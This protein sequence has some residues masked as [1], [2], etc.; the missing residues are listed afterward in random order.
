[1]LLD[2][3]LPDFGAADF[4]LALLSANIAAGAAILLVLVARGPVRRAAGARLAYWLWLTP[5]VA[6]FAGLIPAA[7]AQVIRIALPAMPASEA[8]PAVT[9]EPIA[10]TVAAITPAIDPAAILLILWVAGTAGCL[11]LVLARQARTMRSFTTRGMAGPAVVGVIRPRVIEPA[12]FEQRFSARERELILAHERTHIGAGDTRV[13]A[14][15]ALLT[16]FNWFNPLVHIA[17]RLARTDQELACDAAVVERFPGERRIYAEALLKTQLSPASLPLGCTWPTRSSNLLK[18]RVMMLARKSPG[19]A[20]RTAGIS[21]VAL[22]A[23]GA[24]LAAWAAQPNPPVYVFEQP[25][26]ADTPA[27]QKAP[28]SSE[29]PKDWLT[30]MKLMAQLMMAYRDRVIPLDQIIEASVTAELSNGEVL[31][32]YRMYSSLPNDIRSSEFANGDKG[33]NSDGDDRFVGGVLGSAGADGGLT[34]DFGLVVDGDPITVE[35]LKA[36]SGAS[37]TVE[38]NGVKL[39]IRPVLRAMTAAELKRRIPARK[40]PIKAKLQQDKPAKPDAGSPALD[41]GKRKVDEPQLKFGPG[42]P[43]KPGDTFEMIGPDGKKHQMKVDDLQL[44][45]DELKGPK[46][47]EAFN[48]FGPD[49]KKQRIDGLHLDFGTAKGLK[50]SDPGYKELMETLLKRRADGSDLV[51]LPPQQNPPP[52]KSE[53]ELKS[54]Y[55]QAS[56]EPNAPLTCDNWPSIWGGDPRA[57]YRTLKKTTPV[58]VTFDK[59]G[60]PSIDISAAAAAFPRDLY[61]AGL[62]EGEP[63]RSRMAKDFASYRVKSK[64]VMDTFTFGGLDTDRPSIMWHRVRIAKD[65]PVDTLMEG[66]CRK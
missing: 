30:H 5:I 64:T 45:L 47:G 34:L 60:L 39:T 4:L 13:N 26:P 2:I 31:G 19:R 8:A 66:H 44:Q 25:T 42:K 29:M 16:C 41:G 9:A 6:G 49:G 12:D 33:F 27:P 7:P 43:L 37:V 35:R 36:Q 59:S 56:S 11:A 20:A 23:G 51:Y 24:G 32:P 57:N 28:V 54:A 1:M 21:L 14:V 62:A 38:K 40:G 65:G 52:A 22:L 15:L 63:T 10:A 50:P 46:S 61:P 3:G 18:E 48:F 17:A 55:T 58:I 53:R